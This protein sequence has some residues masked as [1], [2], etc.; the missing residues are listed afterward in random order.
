M[1]TKLERIIKRGQFMS[2]TREFFGSQSFQEIIPPI[3]NNA[4][5]N[6]S[7][8]VPFLT[9]WDNTMEKTN[10][11]LPTSPERSLKLAIAEGIG[12][13]FAIGHCFRNL[14]GSG[15]LHSPEFLMLEWYRENA[16]YQDIIND[17]KQYI[18]Y[19]CEKLD[20][21]E[22]RQSELRSGWT[23]ISIKKVFEGLFK[24]SY[25]RLINE[26]RTLIELAHTI[27]GYNTDRSTWRQIF[28]QVIVN[29][30]ESKLTKNPTFIVDFPSKISPLC[31]TSLVFPF[32]ADRFELYIGGVEIANGN[33]ENL[34]IQTIQKEF[35]NES[36]SSGHPLDLEFISAIQKMQ[37]SAKQYAGV[38]LGLERLMMTLFPEYR[39]IGV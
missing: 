27:L 38:G 19:L 11:Y 35:E 14:E 12:N 32:V 13:C 39:M 17:M 21:E 29:E 16:R 26:E 1:M 23:S 18:Y 22:S 4:V 37:D 30:I 2:A 28:D 20:I 33:N 31:Q 6:E 3:L 34:D 36:K 7:H 25:E 15:S 24:V 5:P 8:L 9:T 10:Y